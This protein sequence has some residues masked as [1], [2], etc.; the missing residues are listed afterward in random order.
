MKD[1]LTLREAKG[2]PLTI[3]EGDTNFNRLMYWSGKW[4][5]GVTYETQQVVNDDGF[6]MVANKT[7]TDHAAPQPLGGPNYGLPDSPTW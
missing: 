7:T 3:N 2:S 1:D 4:L 5:D 6:L